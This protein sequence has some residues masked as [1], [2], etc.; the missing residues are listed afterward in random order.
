L[1]LPGYTLGAQ[2]HR[3]RNRVVWRARRQV[4]DLAV[5][6]KAPV[7]EFPLPAQVAALR[8]EFEILESLAMDG[9][10]RPVELISH[11]DRT[12]LVLA[13]VGDPSLKALLAHAPLDSARAIQLGLRLVAVVGELHR[14][15]FIHKDIN[16]TNILVTPTLDRV[17]LTDFGIASRMPREPQAAHHPQLLE[18][19]IAYMSPEQTGRMNRHVDYRSDY[20]SI[21]VT[22][23]EALTG[24]LP[25]ESSDPLEVIHGHIARRPPAPADLAPGVPQG[26]SHLI[27]K[28]LAKV[29]EERYQSA[30]G[31]RRD[32]ERLAIGAA[33]EPGAIDIP[34]QF[35]VPQR[36]YGR[37]EPIAHLQRAFERVA[38][39]ATELVLVAGSS[40]IGKTAL[41]HELYKALPRHR[42][43]LVSGKYDQLARH[44]PFRALAQ[45]LGAAVLQALAGTP[46]EVAILRQRLA[47]GFGIHAQVLTALVPELERLLGPQPP[48]PELG[49]TEALTRLH[50]LFG[51]FVGVLAQADHPL[52]LFLDDL[53]WADAATLALLPVLLHEARVTGLLFIG[54]Y[55]DAEVSAGHP[56]LH[57]LRELDDRGVPVQQVTLPPLERIHLDALVQDTLRTDPA[58]AAEVADVVLA[59]TEGNPLFV[60]QLLESL[61]RDGLLTFDDL[62]GGWRVDVAALRRAA[63]ADN[64]LALMAEK[65]GRLPPPTQHVLRLA[66]CVG[67][68]FD[69]GTLATIS[70]RPAADVVRDLW[71]AVAEGL[72]VPA[73]NTYGFAPDLALL[74]APDRLRYAFLHDRV[75]QAAYALIPPGDR[76]A[77]HLTIGRLLHSS[78]GADVPR[79]ALFDVVNH[80]NLGRTLLQA[81]ADRLELARLDLAAG[82]HARNAA[83]WP[84]ARG[85]FAI[86]AELLP[87]DPWAKE[88]ALAFPVHLELAEALYLC[89]HPDEAERR[90]L[91]LVQRTNSALEHAEVCTLL[92]TVYET[93]ARYAEAIAIGTLGLQ[94]LD[95]AIPT[96]PSAWD[97]ALTAEIAAI[98]AQ[99]GDRAIATLV[100]LPVVTD[101][102]LRHAMALLQAMWVSAYVSGAGRLGDLL[103]ARIVRLSLQHGNTKASA[104]GYLHHAI[105]VGSVLGQYERGAEFGRLALAVNERFADLRLRAVVYH[106]FAA[107]VNAWRQPFADCVAHA[108][109]AV[110]AASESGNLPVAGYAEFQQA[111]YGMHIDRSL[112]A[113]L[114]R[115]RP[116]VA[117]LDRLQI[118]AYADMQ[119]V[120]VQWAQALAGRTTSP[121]ELG[122][123]DFDESAYLAGVGQ[124]GIFRAL[125]ATVRLELLHTFG[126][127]DEA[128]AWAAQEEAAAEVFVGSIWPAMFVVRHLLV[129]A[130]LRKVAPAGRAEEVDAKAAQLLA[131]LARWAES[132]PA[133]FRH[134]H[135]LVTAELARAAGRPHDAMIAYDQAL[136]EGA[137]QDSPRHRALINELY[138]RFWLERGQPRVAAVFLEEARFGYALWGA[139]AKVADLERRHGALLQSAAMR[140]DAATGRQAVLLTTE[141]LEGALDVAGVMKAAQAL[142]REM[143]LERLLARL[144]QVALETG[145]ADRAV[146]VLERGGQPAVC[147]VGD[148]G[149]VRILPEPGEALDASEAVPRGLVHWVRRTH[150][151]AIVADAQADER[152]R[153]DPYVVRERPRSILCTPV[154]NLG[155]V[156]G[157]LYMENRLASHAFTEDRVRVM[158]LLTAQAAI[159]IE[160]A[161][162]FEDTRRE[163]AERSRA[164]AKLRTLAEGTASVTGARFFPSLVQ[165][166]AEGLNARYAFAAECFGTSDRRVRTLAFWAAGQL[167]T[168]IEYP[169]EGTPCNQVCDGTL[170][171]HPTHVQQLFP[172]D[173]D[174]AGLG[175]D[176]YVGVPL[177]SSTGGVLGHLAVLDVKPMD[178]ADDD[179]R[180]LSIFA[181]RAG[182]ELERQR[183]GDDLR[184]SQL[185][186]STMAEAVP[187]IL[188]TTNADGGTDYLSRRFA[189]YTGLAAES[190]LGDGWIAAVHPDDRQLAD[191]AWHRALRIGGGPFEVEYRL[192]SAA[193]D[194]R[195]FRSRATPVDAGTGSDRRWFGVATDIDDSKRAEAALMSAL[196]EV[197]Q[198]K[199]RLEKENVY[200]QE[201]LETDHGFEDLI[202]RSQALRRML[203][204]AEQVAPGDTTVL[205]TGETGTGKEL[206]ARAIH[207]LSPRRDRPLI[208]IN[209]GAV[210]PGLVESELFGHEKGAF[211]GALA[212]RIGRFEVADGG[213]LFLDEI[214][215]LPLDLQVKLLRVLQEGEV[216]RVGGQK[217][218]RVDVRV[219]AATHRDLEALVKDEK[220]RADLYYRL[221]V[222]PVR[223]PALRERT[224]D[225]PELVRHFVIKYA[226]KLRKRI[227]TIPH[228]VLDRLTTWP[229]PG[230]IREL[231]NVIERSVILARGTSLELD[232]KLAGRATAPGR[233]DGRR[234]SRLEA[235]RARIIS[236]LEQTGWRVSGPRGA[237]L[238]L[239]LKPT[240]LEARMKKLGIRRPS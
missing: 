81:E 174:L 17:T 33:L 34:E 141:T 36:L 85:Y 166:L 98:R 197:R 118:H 184:E 83:A 6:I 147:V 111:W 73:D 187:E 93:V 238:L 69:L 144:M 219:I 175:V 200:L 133:N 186:Y 106:R 194:Y 239:G 76:S 102:G 171:L 178:L 78:A 177:R 12:A 230:N 168:N 71:V 25:F 8:R 54:S 63:I 22:L 231:A 189:D 232:D 99:L 213:T 55:R 79:E 89:G 152:S 225:I 126:R 19:T 142:S 103:A 145:G 132:A 179:L 221:N 207:R 218:V 154:L 203:A 150:D 13:D 205:I 157:A 140:P 112:D 121:L 146:L 229:W 122:G 234:R 47:E 50:L 80:L 220:F 65:L 222:F 116:T 28:L 16:P 30:N 180:L 32:L 214:G 104:F 48:A 42:G 101:P 45:A 2:I 191:A 224:E 127:I 190:G 29:P 7:S 70:A 84:S 119:R 107:L 165:H 105:T 68:R 196:E 21:G 160:N 149:G 117:L 113:F 233:P 18:G 208:A 44:V 10:V 164:V 130:E 169:L 51:R 124:G 24:R 86:A 72:V 216:E 138:G 134:L 193:G 209:C 3:G 151:A 235:D 217:P 110:R 185:R 237:A 77:V 228:D 172:D 167:V 60:R 56:L 74:E 88:S 37:D 43:H 46:D 9:V 176:S 39:G 129:L 153:H 226:T 135:L 15:R 95:V 181:A 120:M 59:K 75:Q 139:A 155:S 170:C 66:A 215:D 123:P 223:C 4:D 143:D 183:T 195:W 38:G 202:G 31:L 82:R 26:L 125:H 94:R 159:A 128:A 148:G 1:I 40:G 52:V 236:A 137:S 23:F 161:R 96:D 108:R 201:Q 92:I 90:F 100:D 49:G 35:V 188:Y 20:Y 87:P 97:G 163:M 41:I 136:E 158:Q 114:E 198:L 131:R 204:Q 53:Q 57:A 227:D 5:I 211:T 115:H 240:T 182:V 64:V 206:L 199:E 162:L 27:L 11:R 212:R 192:R 62:H 91:D 61:H 14:R 173:L 67:N 210:A 58:H 109:E 156:V